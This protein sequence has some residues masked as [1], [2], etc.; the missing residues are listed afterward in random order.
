MFCN[1]WRLVDSFASM[2]RGSSDHID[3][4]KRFIDPGHETFPH[5]DET[6][7]PPREGDLKQNAR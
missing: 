1:F 4:A 5:A 3:P 7:M 2:G 6:I